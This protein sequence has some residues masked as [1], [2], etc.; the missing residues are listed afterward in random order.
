MI[1]VLIANAD[2]L[3]NNIVHE[4]VR[5]LVSTLDREGYY[6]KYHES[7][8]NIVNV[9]CKTKGKNV[10]GDIRIM[11]KRGSFRLEDKETGKWYSFRNFDYVI[12]DP[13]FIESILIFIRS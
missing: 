1:I 8:S 2:E 7:N 13:N 5:K 12:D 9:Y 4:K 11:S 6:L 3:F 10:I